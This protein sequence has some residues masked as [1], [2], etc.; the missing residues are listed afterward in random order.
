MAIRN[1]NTY[2]ELGTEIYVVWIRWF[3]EYENKCDILYPI[4]AR[5]MNLGRHIATLL[6][7]LLT[8]YSITST[9]MNITTTMLYN[10][11]TPKT[12][13]T[14]SYKNNKADDTPQVP[15]NNVSIPCGRDSRTTKKHLFLAV[16]SGVVLV[17]GVVGNFLVVIVVFNSHHLRRQPTYL[18][19]ASLAVADLGVSLFVTTVKVFD[20]CVLF[21]RKSFLYKF[22]YKI[23]ATFDHIN[24]IIG[25]ITIK[26][27]VVF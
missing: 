26:G 24:F 4:S 7:L 10:D 27:H 2:S 6:L 17:V 11:S 23:A 8:N 19:L 15:H 25:G 3:R 14:H 9:T 13:K 1:V 5:T 22:V 16:L 21:L 20:L 12:F 18:F